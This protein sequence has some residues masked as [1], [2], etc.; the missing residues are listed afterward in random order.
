MQSILKTWAETLLDWI[1]AT[2]AQ[3]A[4]WDRWVAVALVV[5]AVLLFDYLARM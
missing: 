4:S 3:H 1:G 5:A 2:S